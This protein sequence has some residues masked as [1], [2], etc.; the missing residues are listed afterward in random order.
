MVWRRL[1]VLNGGDPVSKGTEIRADAVCHPGNRFVFDYLPIGDAR[2]HQ[3]H[4]PLPVGE[5]CGQRQRI[6]RRRIL[7][8]GLTCIYNFVFEKT[9][10]KKCTF[11]VH[12]NNFSDFLIKIL[13]IDGSF[14]F[15][16]N[17]KL[18]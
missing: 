12:I 7:L 6:I 16:Q 9:K 13:L 8:C 17:I 18:C 11:Y 3:G 14:F 2:P 10:K 4:C 1:I 15:N 5:M